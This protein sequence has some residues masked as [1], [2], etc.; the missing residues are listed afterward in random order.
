MLTH[1]IPSKR[2][3]SIGLFLLVFSIYGLTSSGR[4]DTNI[5]TQWRYEVASN[6]LDRRSSAVE[7]PALIRTRIGAIGSDGRWYSTHSLGGSLGGMPAMIFARSVGAADSELERFLFSISNALYGSFASIALL[8]IYRDIGLSR[9]RS[10]AWSLCAAFASFIWPLSTTSLDNIQHALLMLLSLRAGRLATL[11]N[12]PKYALTSGFCAGLLIAHQPSFVV[13]APA[14]SLSMLSSGAP[15]SSSRSAAI[16]RFTLFA[17]PFLTGIAFWI[18]YNFTRFAM[19]FG[20][21][22]NPAIAPNHPPLLGNPVLGAISLLFS[23][24][25]SI[26]LYSPTIIFGLIGLRY[27][28]HRE[29]SLASAIAFTSAAHFTLISSLTFFGGDW[30]WGPRYLG[31]L[32]AILAIAAPFATEIFRP[33]LSRALI[34]FGLAVQLLAISTDHTIFFLNRGLAPFFWY[35]DKWFYFH[36]SQ[37]LTRPSEAAGLFWRSK[38]PNARLFGPSIHR[39]SPTS[40]Q[41]GLSAEQLPHTRPLFLVYQV[42]RPWPFWVPRV[43]HVLRPVSTIPTVLTL[44]GIGLLGAFC[45]HRS[46]ADQTES[47]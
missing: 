44:V 32:V 23:P 43:A 22:P 17:L 16:Q 14:L 45:L 35:H 37:L 13:S 26:F 24:G 5:D 19:P 36:S 1:T 15:S 40:A 9:R 11:H 31:S 33:A 27:L 28:R 20:P 8:G 21:P 42:P 34:I 25:K 6:I 47:E 12:S 4:F 30:C 29:R 3:D 39:G 18:W 7:D 2:I 46:R 41:M 10:L 38:P